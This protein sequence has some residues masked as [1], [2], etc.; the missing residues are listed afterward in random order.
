MNSN[1]RTQNSIINFG[2]NIIYQFLIILISFITRRIFIETLGMEYLGISGLFSNILGILTLAELG[3]GSAMSFSMYKYIA[4]KDYGKLQALNS[5]YKTL[6]NRIALTVLIIGLALLPFLKYIV[7][8]ESDINNIE[9]YYLIS[10]LN[11]VFSYL[12]VYKTTIVNADQSGYK[13]KIINIAF[14]FLKAFLQIISLVVFRNYIL[15]LLVQVIITLVSNF[16]KSSITGNLYPFINEKAELE[17]EEKKNIWINIKS[18]FYYKVGGV[19]MDS[20]DNVLISI[21][22]NTTTVGIYSNYTMIINKIGAI[23]ALLFD[24]IIASIGNL[25]AT[26][27]KSKQYSMHKLL[28]LMAS[29]FY[30]IASVGIYH[31]MEDVIT[32]ISGTNIFLLDKSILILSVIS[33]YITGIIRPNYMYRNTSGL[34]KLGKNAML[35]CSILNIVLSI[36]LGNMYGLFGIILA[37]IL[38]RLFTNVW[39]EPFLL[40]KCFF[41]KS[42]KRYYMNQIYKI[43]LCILMTLLLIPVM[44]LIVIENLYVRILIKSITCIVFC[45]FILFNVY[46]KNP[47]F[48]ILITKIYEILKSI[49]NNFKKKK[50]L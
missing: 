19:L 24:S 14:E 4:K 32:A 31:L 21:L 16:V 8:I 42:P 22:I 49:Q 33:F 47:E 44:N 1:T 10:L 45:S 13:L 35:I 30:T 27:S 7:N 38:S 39:Y 46:R 3:I 50:I 9:I 11:S 6:Y 23:I 37:T 41:D 28:D 17:V 43:I 5:Y 29:I 25:N 48:K 20:T 40:Y 36:V 26:T 15:F 2:V 34:F 12:F 18:M